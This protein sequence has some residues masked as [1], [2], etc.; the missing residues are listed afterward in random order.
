MLSRTESTK[1]AP[2]R[3]EGKEQVFRLENIPKD[4]IQPRTGNK[5]TKH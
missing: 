1:S 3:E 5:S 2:K 4:L